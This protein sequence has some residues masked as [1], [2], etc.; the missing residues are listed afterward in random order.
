MKPNGQADLR[1]ASKPRGGSLPTILITGGAGF[2]GTNLADELLSAGL[3]V[4]VYDNLS[5][6][7]SEINLEWLSRKHHELLRVELADVRNSDRL[8]AVIRDADAVFHFAAQVAVTDSLTNPRH[9]FDVNVRGTFNVLEAIRSSLHRPPLFFTSTN[10]VYGSMDDHSLI[11][12]REGYRPAHSSPGI[13]ESQPLDFHSPYGCSKGAAEQYVLD[14]ARSYG[15]RNVVFR[16]SCIYGPH[17]FGNEDQGWIAHFLIRARDHKQITIY[18]DG[19]QVRDVLFVNDLVAAFCSAWQQVEKVS[20]QPFNIGGGASNI[21]SLLQLT[22]LIEQLQGYP[23]SLSYSDWRCGD[24]RYYV[25][26]T[27]KFTTATGWRPTVIVRDGVT[28]LYRWL[29]EQRQA[30]A[31]AS[32]DL[33]TRS[34]HLTGSAELARS[35]SRRV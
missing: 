17:Q 33:E 14:Y 34:P 27:D 5:R 18:G 3:P 10:K 13:D 1:F 21:L 28:A 23:C 7:G 22:E 35:E 26:C 24:Q 32:Y 4:I 25:S 29:A 11:K 15:L 20:G 9:D 12:T 19:L 6:S 31:G 2:I 16:M 8:H 30:R